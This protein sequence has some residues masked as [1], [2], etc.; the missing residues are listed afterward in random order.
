MR[1]TAPAGHSLPYRMA[2]SGLPPIPPSFRWT[3]R[4][5]GHALEC[6][7]LAAAAPHGWTTRQLKFP[8]NGTA[9][10]SWEVLAA[11]VGRTA[12]AV[13]HLKQVH[14]ARVVH[15]EW[16]A[17]VEALGA[18]A[19]V[20]TDSRRVL[21]VRTAD[22]VPLLLADARSGAVAAVHA[23]W[24][25]SAAGVVAGAVHRLLEIAGSSAD[26][27]VAAVGPSIGPCCYRVGPELVGA[28]ERGG[29]DVRAWFSQRDG[30]Y[31]DLWRATRD[32]LVA[33]G[34]RDDRT[35]IAA[36]CT[37]CHEPWFHSYRRD[38]AAAGRLVGYIRRR[39]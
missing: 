24:R 8:R 4:S 33:A 9:D 17:D 16:P 35:H 26:E 6:V 31:L 2:E 29:H 18:D 23:G 27:V 19:V 22:C 21:S 12:S 7:P 30:L 15:A 3:R 37:A 34:V 36:L 25:G 1:L 32:Q 28:F 39:D 13:R 10:A 20:S 38:G 5:W 11:S 14:G